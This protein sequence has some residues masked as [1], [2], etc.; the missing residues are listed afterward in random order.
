MSKTPTKSKIWA[1]VGFFLPAFAPI[2]PKED[3]KKML[4]N[5]I[6]FQGS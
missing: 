3:E 4:H 1:N 6:Y 5:Y 2:C